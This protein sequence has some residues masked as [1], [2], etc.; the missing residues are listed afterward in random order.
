MYTGR[1]ECCQLLLPDDFLPCINQKKWENKFRNLKNYGILY[2]VGVVLCSVLQYL[3]NI[4]LQDKR[5][6]HHSILLN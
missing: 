3:C 6:L 2:V 5:T 1:K 4:I